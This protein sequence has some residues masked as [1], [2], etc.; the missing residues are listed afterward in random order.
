MLNLSFEGSAHINVL[1]V[2]NG[3][4][5]ETFAQVMAPSIIFI[6]R[7]AILIELRVKITRLEG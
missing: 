4:N 6:A 2:E 1:V 3:I 5:I 7:R